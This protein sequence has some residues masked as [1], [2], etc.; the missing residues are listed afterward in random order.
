MPVVI[1]T[2]PILDELYSEPQ[3]AENNENPFSDSYLATAPHENSSQRPSSADLDSTQLPPYPESGN[4]V[5]LFIY[6]SI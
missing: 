5:F 3:A 4:G 6:F 1:G 2:Y